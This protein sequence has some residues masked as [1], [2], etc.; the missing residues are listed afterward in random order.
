MSKP[1]YT[2]PIKIEDCEELSSFLKNDLPIQ[3]IVSFPS[4]S[5]I[6]IEFTKSLLYDLKSKGYRLDL[7]EN[8][9]IIDVYYPSEYD[10]TYQKKKDAIQQHHIMARDNQLLKPSIR[11]FIRKM[12]TKK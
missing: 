9:G 7:N 10:D 5:D 1:D 2:I 3:K 12:E 11:E 8:D 4:K 6:G